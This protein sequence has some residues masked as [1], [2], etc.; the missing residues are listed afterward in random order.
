M[1][2]H[3]VIPIILASVAIGQAQAQNNTILVH[4]P[5][6]QVTDTIAATPPLE[7]GSAFMP[8]GPGTL[9]GWETLS[10]Q[11]WPPGFMGALA[12]YPPY[13]A[14]AYD[15]T[16]FPAR[17]AGELRRIEGDSSRAHCSAQLVGPWH[18]LT[19]AHCLRRLGT[20]A[21]QT[22]RLEFF[23]AFDDGMPS[24]FGSAR[25]ALYYVPMQ[26]SQ[27]LGLIQLDQPLGAELGWVGLGFT[28][29]TAFFTDRVVHKFCYPADASVLNT[30]LVYN[31][32]TL[33]HFSKVMVRTTNGMTDYLGV[34]G[35]L[36]IPG[37]SGGGAWVVRDNAYQVM[38]VA[39][40][41]SGYRHILLNA[42]IFEQFRTILENPS[43]RIPALAGPEIQVRIR[44]NP[45]LSHAIFELADPLGSTYT[46]T[47]R[48]MSGR[49]AREQRFQGSACTFSR[50]GLAPGCYVYHITDGNGSFASGKL[51]IGQ[52][53]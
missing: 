48:D 5:E 40:L 46:L 37:E 45:V 23:P 50:D 39:S 43:L 41:S 9:P 7:T 15:L 24:A 29:D 19:A 52:A 31:G 4:N 42:E 11:E 12:E 53:H 1:R 13:A 2:K 51:T 10:D 20:G 36:G 33:Y 14:D 18:V 3:G 49:V 8:H 16:T 30:E 17:V 32:D 44:P 26:S 35:W 38:G 28:T 27:D 34:P 47:I 21:W 22:G 25:A 6:T